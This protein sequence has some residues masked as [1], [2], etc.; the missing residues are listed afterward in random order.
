MTGARPALS[1]RLRLMGIAISLSA[2]SLLAPGAGQR[3]RAGRH[4]RPR[5]GGDR[6]GGQHLDLADRKGQA[7]TATAAMPQ[8]PEGSPFQDFFDD[9]FKESRRRG[10]DQR[11]MQPESQFARLG[12]R[13]RCRGHR[14]HQQS[15]H[16]R[17][18]RDRGDLQ[19]R[20]QAQG[21][22]GRHRH[23][24]RPS[25]CCGSSRRSPDGG[26][27]R[28]FRQAAHRRVGD[29]DR[30]SVRAR[31]HRDRRHRL[32]AQ[33]R[34]QVHGPYDSYIQ[35][36]AAINRGNSGG[37]LFNMDGEVVGINTAIISPTRWL[38]RHRF[39]RAVEAVAG[40]VEQLREFGESAPRLARRPHPAGHRRHRRK[41]RHGPARGALVAGI[42]DKGPVKPAGLEPGDVI[43]KFDGKDVKDARD[44]PRVVAATPVGK[45]VT[46]W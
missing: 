17:R 29:G 8:L 6:C 32:G 34:H 2:A 28:R 15:R 9:F 27:V 44:L 26:E 30:Q 22:A 1:R 23:Q 25:P 40:V 3:A 12:L 36:D 5:R 45:A 14:R 42:D 20:P 39:R 4:R 19:R 11:R 37:P 13:R 43:V 16:R 41:P 21:R 24:D 10:G 31:R 38:D 33:P 18:R 35:T 7:A 46:C